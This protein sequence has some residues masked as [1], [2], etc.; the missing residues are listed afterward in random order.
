M[1]RRLFQRV[2]SRPSPAG[3]PKTAHAYPSGDGTN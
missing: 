1:I 3:R 2:L